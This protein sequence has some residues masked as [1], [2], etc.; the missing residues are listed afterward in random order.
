MVRRSAADAAAS[1][2]RIV[3]S[4]SRL[5]RE[6]GYAGAGIDAIVRDAG[7]TPGAFY[8]HFASKADLFAEVVNEALAE[9]KRH[10]PAIDTA[11]DVQAFVNFYLSNKAVRELGAGCIV[12]AM[13][14]DL[15][16]DGSGAREAAGRYIAL[17]HEQIAI[18]LG[19]EGGADGA[20]NAWRLVAQLIGGLVVARILPSAL[21]KTALVS[22]RTLASPPSLRQ[23]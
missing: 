14:A 7:L 17:I 5:M 9:A 6:H 2:Q 3:R 21:A 20:E 12:A 1:R 13:S 11:A 22:A 16:R 8:R 18:A 10:L 19:K 4:A 15:A 23:A